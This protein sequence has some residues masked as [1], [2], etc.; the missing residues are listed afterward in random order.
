MVYS[1]ENACVASSLPRCIYDIQSRVVITRNG[2]MGFSE[3]YNIVCI[4][5]SNLRA[6]QASSTARFDMKAMANGKVIRS[7]KGRDTV[8]D[9]STVIKMHESAPR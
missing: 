7:S 3:K 8:K 6:R 1:G 4:W 9:V 2:M 5:A